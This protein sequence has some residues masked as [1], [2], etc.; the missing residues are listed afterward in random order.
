M[1]ERGYHLLRR[2]SLR[3]KIADAAVA[4]RLAQFLRGRLH[5]QRVM[6]KRGLLGSPEQPREEN[7]PPCG[8]EQIFTANYEI[9]VLEPVVDG[10]GELIRPIPVAISNQHVAA[11]RARLLRLRA[12]PQI[13]ESHDAVVE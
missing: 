5:E 12:Q 10:D 13:V 2:P 6:K 9:H 4:V 11:L 7:L 1:C 8:V 3:A